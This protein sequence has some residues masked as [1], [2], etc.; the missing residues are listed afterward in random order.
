M[1]FNTFPGDTDYI[2]S[3]AAHMG[4]QNYRHG[5]FLLNRLL[6]VDKRFLANEH[7]WNDQVYVAK[8]VFLVNANTIARNLEIPSS[9]EK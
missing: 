2:L 4:R 1:L 5:K 8:L 3:V 7:S 6:G 9:C